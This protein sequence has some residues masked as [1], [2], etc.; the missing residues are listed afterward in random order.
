MRRGALG[1]GICRL[2]GAGI[3]CRHVPHAS[4]QSHGELAFGGCILFTLSAPRL[5]LSDNLL[6]CANAGCGVLGDER[7]LVRRGARAARD[8]D[9]ARKVT[10][11]L[12][13]HAAVRAPLL[14]LGGRVEEFLRCLL[15]TSPS[16]RDRG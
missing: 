5:A 10:E 16:P 12:E 2:G 14:L 1:V 9:Q 15:Y 7:Q 3:K 8:A 11:R 6:G 13:R 4:D